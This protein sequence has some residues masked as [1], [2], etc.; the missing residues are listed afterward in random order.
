MKIHKVRVYPSKAKLPKE[1]Q[2]AWIIA[3]AA[4]DDVPV[5]EAVCS[6]II[7]RIMDNAAEANAHPAGAKPFA[8]SD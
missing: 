8:R 2:L 7:N 3:A 1:K 6:M 4:S 5:E